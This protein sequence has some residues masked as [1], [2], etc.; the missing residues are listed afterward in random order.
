ME[1][2]SLSVSEVFGVPKDYTLEQLK[3]SYIDI[4][5]NLLKSDRTKV[6]KDLLAD[7]YKKLYHKGKQM[8]LQRVSAETDIEYSYNSYPNQNQL[9]LFDKFDRMIDG[10]YGLSK[11]MQEYNPFTMFDNMYSRMNKYTDKYTDQ[12]M[13]QHANT[14]VYSY[15]STHSSKI[16]PDGSTTVIEKKT[17]S[18]NGNKKKTINAWKR[19]PDGKIVN[20]SDD[21]MKELTKMSGLQ[22]EN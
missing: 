22:I 13:N 3:K 21:E 15:S 9:D 16:N 11:R 6:E 4:M 12:H 19:M 18:T 5:E 7:Q 20:L 8:Y 1:G 17:E 2:L 10:S 14:K